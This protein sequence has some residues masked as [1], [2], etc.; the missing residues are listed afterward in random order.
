[1]TTE[2]LTLVLLCEAKGN[3]PLDMQ[4]VI[5]QLICTRVPGAFVSKKDEDFNFYSWRFN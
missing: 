3:L 5:K 4:S 1:M 2:C